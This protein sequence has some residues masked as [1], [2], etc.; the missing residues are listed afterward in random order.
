LLLKALLAR[1]PHPVSKELIMEDLWPDATPKTGENNLRVNLH[2]LRKALEPTLD[3]DFGSAYLQ[4]QGNHLVLDQDLCQIDAHDFS[5]LCRKGR[6]A[7]AQGDASAALALYLVAVR[8]YGGDFLP[9]EPYAS[10]AV[11]RPGGTAPHLSGHLAAPGRAS[12]GP[13]LLKPGWRIPPAG[14]PG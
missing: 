8:L 6:T 9:D 11:S 7:E 5:S 1:G 2:R 14:S 3:K 13:G 10:W 12:R 4:F